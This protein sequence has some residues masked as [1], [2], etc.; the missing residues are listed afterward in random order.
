MVCVRLLALLPAVHTVGRPGG[1]RQPGSEDLQTLQAASPR[2]SDEGGRE[3]GKSPVSSWPQSLSRGP[4]EA[5]SP[6]PAQPLPGLWE[7]IG[8]GS[9]TGSRES[10]GLLHPKQGP[11][12]AA[13]QLQAADPG[14]L[15]VLDGVG[16]IVWLVLSKGED[17]DG[18]FSAPAVLQLLT[19]VRPC[20]CSRA[21]RKRRAGT[22]FL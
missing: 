11:L 1:S 22:L 21:P 12:R 5:G 7:G 19:Q 9:P 4:W 16:A 17:C 15:F 2:A 3:G 18:V 13:Q 20:T 10:Q 14:D 8:S 6:G